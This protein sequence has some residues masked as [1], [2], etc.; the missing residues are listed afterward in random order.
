MPTLILRRALDLDFGVDV[1]V[2]DP[3]LFQL[4]EQSLAGLPSAR[5]TPSAGYR[6]TA[7]ADGLSLAWGAE[8]VRTTASRHEVL[9][10][11]V[12]HL[13]LASIAASR[14]QLLLHAG[15][16]ALPDGRVIVL[17]AP[18]G[19]GKTTL[20]AELVGTGLA[21]LTDETLGVDPVS[22][23]VTP[24]RKP[25][26]VKPGSFSVL[27]HLAPEGVDGAEASLWQVPVARL[28]GRNLPEVPLR[29]AAGGGPGVCGRRLDRAAA[30]QRR[31]GGVPARDQLVVALRRAAPAA[32]F[33]G[34][35]RRG[36]A[37]VS[38]AVLRRGAGARPGALGSWRNR[39]SAARPERRPMVDEVD[40]DGE[41]VAFDGTS[42]HHLA[43]PATAVWRLAD[44]TLTAGQI[45]DVL[46]D[47]YG[48]DRAESLRRVDDIVGAFRR[49]GLI[50]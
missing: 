8:T 13:N 1:D 50:A 12:G 4:L 42:V 24:Y 37:H 47:A 35:A 38:V 17:P 14:G 23:A 15:A 43:G 5:T 7:A 10:A 19:S 45:A 46:A 22:L 20:T 25:L 29:V 11:L 41:I 6:V 48:V 18:S 21:Y 36:G 33:A 3:A 34:S 9:D 28:G 16:V 39:V 40:L 44:G 2:E 30:D 32:G 27:G 26:T 49:L 31:R